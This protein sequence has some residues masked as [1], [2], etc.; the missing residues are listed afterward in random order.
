MTDGMTDPLP[1][2]DALAEIFAVLALEAGAA[3]MRVLANP[4]M[5]A[6]Q[7]RF[8][9]G[10]RRRPVRRRDHS[11]RPRAPRPCLSGRR[12]G[13]LRQRQNSQARRRRLLSWSTPLDGTREFLAAARLFHG[14]YRPDPRR[15]SG[16]RRRVRA[17]ARRTLPGRRAGPG[18]ARP[19]RGPRLPSRSRWR[20]LRARPMP[21][22]DAIALASRS[23]ATRRSD[24]FLAGCRSARW[25]QPAPR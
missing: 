7:E 9:P 22:R 4:H 6:D 11:Q 13:A 21:E 8:Q 15:R 17:G 16:G 2:D 12:R 24:H 1:E 19:C 5:R 20:E 25:F 10:L 14:Q 23:T 18:A 3:I